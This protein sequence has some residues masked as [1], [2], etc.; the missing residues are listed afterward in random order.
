MLSDEY[1][2]KNYELYKLAIKK[3]SLSEDC[4]KYSE[5]EMEYRNAFHGWLQA[6]NVKE[7]FAD[8]DIMRIRMLFRAEK[9]ASEQ[10]AIEIVRAAYEHAE[11]KI[12]RQFERWA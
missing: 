8:N 1:I 12:E 11:S 2:I 9:P 3:S 10:H 4:N 5:E 6:G 7:E